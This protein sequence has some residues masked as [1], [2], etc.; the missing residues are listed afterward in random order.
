M[1]YDAVLKGE[2]GEKHR[3]NLLPG[4]SRI[5]RVR[6][7][8]WSGTEQVICARGLAGATRIL[9]HLEFVFLEESFQETGSRGLPVAEELLHILSSHRRFSV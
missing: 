4:Q 5:P 3:C 2:S 7:T 1:P 8:S 6:E 9:E